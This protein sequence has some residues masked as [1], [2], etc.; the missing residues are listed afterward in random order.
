LLDNIQDKRTDLETFLT[1]EII[2]MFCN[3]DKI[4]FNG[5]G[6]FYIIEVPNIKHQEL[7]FVYI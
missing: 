3:T 7:D 2:F 5:I 6:K 4:Y 1:A